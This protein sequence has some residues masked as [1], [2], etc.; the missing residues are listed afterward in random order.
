[1]RPRGSPGARPCRGLSPRAR[2]AG[3][4]GRAGPSDGVGH[5]R[6]PHDPRGVEEIG[7][8]LLGRSSSSPMRLL[9]LIVGCLTDGPRV[10]RSGLRRART[11][12]PVRAWRRTTVECAGDES[13]GGGRAAD[14]GLRCGVVAGSSLVVHS[15]VAGARRAVPRP[16]RHRRAAAGRI[17]DVRQRRH[18]RDALHHK[19]LL[20][21]DHLDTPMVARCLGAGLGD[22]VTRFEPPVG[23]SRFA[24]MTALVEPDTPHEACARLLD[25]VRAGSAAA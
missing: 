15:V 2:L 21:L 25:E 16:R 22:P 4:R 9:I 13:G 5:P 18:E 11:L 1:M 24:S 14:V 10:R 3:L 7:C 17:G 8:T 6:R 12:R 20:G 23:R 19:L